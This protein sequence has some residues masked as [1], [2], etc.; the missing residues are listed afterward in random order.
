MLQEY[1]TGHIRMVDLNL[2]DAALGGTEGRNRGGAAKIKRLFVAARA[3]RSISQSRT[4]TNRKQRRSRPPINL[5]LRLSAVLGHLSPVSTRVMRVP[6]RV[7]TELIQPS[8]CQTRG[9]LAA[10]TQAEQSFH[11]SAFQSSSD[12][13]LREYRCRIIPGLCESVEHA[14]NITPGNT[15]PKHTGP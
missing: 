1:H 12:L 7:L 6:G 2:T 15:I 5:P 11:Y 13:F 4:G 10:V 14:A 8:R 9:V 3:A